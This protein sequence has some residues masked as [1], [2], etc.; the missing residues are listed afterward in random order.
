M[1]ELPNAPIERIIKN[2]GAKR[3]SKNATELMKESL[4]DFGTNLSKK[5]SEFAAHAGRQTIYP[6]DIKLALKN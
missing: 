6:E 4:E 3:V 2:T 1:A 5:A